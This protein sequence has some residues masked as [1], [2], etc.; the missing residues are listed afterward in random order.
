MKDIIVTIDGHAGSGKS[1]TA[2]LLAD[3]LGLMYLDTGAMYRAVT[4]AVISRGIDPED[5][6]KV[7]GIAE[8]ISIELKDSDGRPVFFLDGEEVESKIRT[9]EV[10]NAVSPVSQHRGV[11]KSM[12]RI[13]RKIGAGGGI[14][15]EGRD[16]G[17]TVFPSAEVKVFLEAD[18]EARVERRVAQMRSM[19]MDPDPEEIRRNIAERDSIDS[20]REHSPLRKAPG[21]VVVN[22][23]TTTIEGQVDIIEKAVR[24][25]YE[26][27]SQL[28]IQRGQPSGSRK[29][30]IYWRITVGA[31]YCFFRIVFGLKVYGMENLLYRENFIIASNHISYADPLLVGCVVKREIWFMAKIELFKNRFLGWLIRK[32]HAFPVKR[33]AADRK[34]IKVIFEKLADGYSVLLFPEG[35][36]S[37]TGEIGKLKSGLG[38]IA[39][40]T[41]KSIVPVFIK[42]AGMLG[43][44]MMRKE[45]LEVRIGRPIRLNPDYVPEDRK[46]DYEIL[47]GMISESLKVLKDESEA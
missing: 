29:A 21:S 9:L 5:E 31:V 8:T 4:Y 46:S 45:K 25:E 16:T 23:S 47:A 13:Q 33:G 42:G 43:R 19:G 17:T 38:F 37:R 24:K 28:R 11:R 20:G 15:A 10:S 22:T 6:E 32:Y 3:R 35:T 2:A 41:G 36:R 44:C 7:S 40:S 27:L 14:V 18:T 26:R 30:P 1:T 39:M 34:S 12:V